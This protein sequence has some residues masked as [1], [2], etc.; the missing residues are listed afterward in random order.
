MTNKDTIRQNMIHWRKKVG[1]TQNE[2]ADRL[3]VSR[4]AVS[5]WERGETLP[6]ILT[7]PAIAAVFA[8]SVDTLLGVKEEPTET[9]PIEE[10]N[11]DYAVTITKNGEV[12]QEIPLWLQKKVSV[13]LQGDCHTFSTTCTTEIQGNV[14]GNVIIPESNEKGSLV[15]IG[16]NVH[17]DVTVQDTVTVQ[18]DVLGSI[19]CGEAYVH[20]DVFDNVSCHLLKVIGCISGHVTCDDCSVEGNVEGSVFAGG[21]FIQND[22]KSTHTDTNEDKPVEETN[23]EP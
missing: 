1:L 8:V 3:H 4:Q 19:H 22:P 15:Y 5:Q 2:L 18:G 6:D 11:A 10:E 17:G 21:H 20:G 16:G 12:L 23:L 13:S 9:I 7:L 14:G